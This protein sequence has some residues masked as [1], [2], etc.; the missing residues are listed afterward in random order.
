MK[1]VLFLFNHDAAHQV[2]HLASVAAAMGRTHPEVATIV[3]YSTPAI[4]DQLRKLIG[5]DD[6]AR[7]DWK[8]LALPG[9]AR[10]AARLFDRVL[11]ATRLLRLRLNAPLFA[12][13]DMVVSTERTCL[14]LKAQLDPAQTP[15]FGFI[16]HG[17]GDRSV[18][19]HPDIT[20]FD[21]VMVSGR[22]VVDQLVSH[23]V[24]PE[25]IEVTGY[26]KFEAVDLSAK[27]DFFGNGKPTF[28]YNP[29]FDPH[30]SSWY[31]AGPE[32]LRW[33]ASDEGQAFN[34]IF[35]PHV[36]LFRKRLHISPEYKVARQRPDIPP[37]AL[38]APNILVDVDSPRLFDMSYMLGADAYI[39][40]V[41][42]QMYEFLTRR[43]P[44]YYLDCRENPREEDDSWHMFWKTGPKVGSIAEL[45]PLLPRYA[46]IGAQYRA[47]QDELLDYTF[48]MGDQPASV[49][50]ADAI[51]R[52]AVG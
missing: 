3:A 21:L 24:S 40:D 25:R 4:R 32:L 36:M 37:E 11:P 13:V 20:R 41:S 15:L 50:A 8:E 5:E 43:R 51:A 31:D 38:S 47:A 49:R 44:A 16:P 39:G 45:T 34:C 42:S 27:P 10:I 9:W 1:R 48:D 29:H 17:S 14:R 26:P 19:Y 35:A 30:L 2:A 18:S 22:K 33:F 12:S 23:G 46:E 6:A 28:V 7:L 52:K